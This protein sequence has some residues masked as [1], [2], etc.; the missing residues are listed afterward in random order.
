MNLSIKQQREQLKTAAA[1][2]VVRLSQAPSDEDRAR[3]EAWRATSID[4]EIAYEQALASWERLDRLASLRAPKIVPDAD[5]LVAMDRQPLPPTLEPAPKRPMQRWLAIAAC[6]LLTVA[7][8]GLLLGSPLIAP[9]YATGIG[10]RRLIVLDDGTRVELNTDSKI[11]VRYVR[12]HREVELVRGEAMLHVAGGRQP[13]VLQ[14]QAG[15]LRMSRS[16]KLDVRMYG[17]AA[18][19]TVQQGAVESL[20]PAQS[21]PEI[22][23]PGSEALVGMTGTRVR[24]IE[25]GDLTRQLAWRDGAISLDGQTI[26]EAIAEINR[27][28]SAQII[29]NDQT[30]GGLRVGGYFKTLSADEFATALSQAF[31]LKVLRQPDG[32]FVLVAGRSAPANKS[33]S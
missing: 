20:R 7:L 26:Y 10:E 11:V 33:S 30:I 17:G 18:K 13:F 3:F 4:H 23:T 19:V 31:G 29:V 15:Q 1:L 28:N 16:A 32:D 24:M 21:E 27:Y 9:A 8:G 12:D 5:L 25:D 14:T 6:L 2:W 22:L